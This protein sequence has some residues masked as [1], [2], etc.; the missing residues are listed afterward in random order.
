MLIGNHHKV[1]M[2]LQMKAK[3]MRVLN[4]S[5]NFLQVYISNASQWSGSC[6]ESASDLLELSTGASALAAIWSCLKFRLLPLFI[7][8]D[9]CLILI[10]LEHLLMFLFLP[11][12]ME[13][14]QAERQHLRMKIKHILYIATRLLPIVVA[15]GFMFRLTEGHESH[16]T[17]NQSEGLTLRISDQN[18]LWPADD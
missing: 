8:V 16:K 4:S 5:I 7:F 18:H 15:K 14:R 1:I 11:K 6:D 10:W 2:D 17:V 9:F 12:I 3:L 13:M